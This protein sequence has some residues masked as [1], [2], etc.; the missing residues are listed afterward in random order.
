MKA[1]GVLALLSV[2]MWACGGG[3]TPSI[4][5]DVSVDPGAQGDVI[6]DAETSGGTD[7]PG[8]ANPEVAPEEGV[9]LPD[10]EEDFWDVANEGGPGEVVE[11]SGEDTLADEG[12]AL[13][14]PLIPCTND[15]DCEAAAVGPCHGLRCASGY[16]EMY[17]LEDGTPC[18]TGSVCELSGACVS[19]QCIGK[20]LDCDDGNVCTDDSCDPKEGCVHKPNSEP[21]DDQN[22]CTDTSTCEGGVCVGHD[23]KCQC[24]TD[25]D[26]A[27]KNDDDLCNGVLH[28]VSGHCE[29]DPN[30]VVKCDG[31]AKDAC[32]TLVCEPKTGQCVPTPA[33]NGTP[34]DDGSKCTTL[35]QCIDG[36]CVGGTP[37]SCDDQNPCTDDAC[38]LAA[39]CTHTPNS[40]PCD[41]QDFCT[42]GDVCKDGKCVGQTPRDCSDG[43]PC[44]DDRCEGTSC[45][46]DPNSAPCDD[47]DPCTSNDYCEQG[48]CVGHGEPDCDDKNP[49][50]QDSCEKG[51]GCVHKPLSAVPCDDGNACTV[52]SGCVD[53]VCKGGTPVACDDNNICTDDSCDPVKG[54]VFTPNSRPCDDQ[55]PCTTGDHCQASECVGGPAPS[56]DDLN[57]CTDDSCDPAKGC[58]HVFN[59][60]PCEDGSACTQNDQCVLGQCV[61]GKAVDCDDNNLCTTDSCDPAKGCV[62]TP[63]TLPCDDGNACTEGDRCSNGVCQGGSTKVCMDGNPCTTDNC[64]PK[65]GCVFTPKPDN[66]TCDDGNACTSN[67]KCSQGQCVG[68][69]TQ[70]NDGNPCTDDRCNSVQGCYYVNNTN[71]CDDNNRCTEGDVCSNGQCAGKPISCDDGNVCT[72]DL[73]DKAIGCYYQFNTKDCE[74]GN[75][76]TLGDKCQ[77][78][79]CVPGSGTPN[80]DDNNPC[81]TDS[82]DPKLGCQNVPNTLPCNDGDVCTEND[83]CSNGQ[84][85]GTPVSCDDH[86]VCTKDVCLAGTGCVHQYVTGPCDDGNKCTSNDQCT[87]GQCSGTPVLCDDHN[88]CTTDSCDPAKG[89]VFTYNTLPCDD[90]KVCTTQDQC[91]GGQCVGGPAPNCD[92]GNICTDD[93]C[94]E[95]DGCFHKNNTLPC[96]DNDACTGPDVCSGG[97]C[98]G[99]AISCDDHNDCTSDWCDHTYGCQHSNV[100]NGTPCKLGVKVG[101]CL[102][103]KCVAWDVKA[104]NPQGEQMTW[105]YEGGRPQAN[106]GLYA[107]GGNAFLPRIYVV[108]SDL[109]VSVAYTYPGTIT[110]GQ[111]Y[112]QFGSL[113]GGSGGIS[114]RYVGAGPVGWTNGPSFDTQQDVLSISQIPPQNNTYFVTGKAAGSWALVQSTIRRCTL[115]QDTECLVMGLVAS[116]NN[117]CKQKAVEL[118][119]SYVAGATRAFAV[120]MEQT[121]IGFGNLVIASWDG[122]SQPL[123]CGDKIQ[124]PGGVFYYD[125]SD[126]SSLMMPIQ[127]QGPG[128]LNDVHG[129]ALNDVW[130]VG[131]KGSVFWYNG[132]KWTQMSPA[133][134]LPSSGYGANHN[135]QSVWVD[136][137]TGVH[138][139]GTRY[140]GDFLVCQVPFYL[141][142]VRDQVS[143]AYKFN[144]YT[145]FTDYQVCGQGE[146]RLSDLYMDSV[147]SAL[148]VFGWLQKATANVQALVM[149]IQRPQTPVPLTY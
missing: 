45:V 118:R 43:N 129:A 66:T 149:R 108:N 52:D 140:S 79:V 22:P 42:V 98:S 81:T 132:M 86:N 142:A 21:C 138:V 62:H 29:V 141:H 128:A 116:K 56:C 70:C 105:L 31:P 57:P 107:S 144:N 73:C 48:L 95:P 54:C 74:D 50:T 114:A 136:P 14:L 2:F 64:D 37:L 27:D 69:G 134:D 143:G 101:M 87:N 25:K 112:A 26:C 33:Q 97:Q 133:K 135:A 90:G 91:Q 40:A 147:S 17:P 120:G 65:T 16:C 71:P 92:D 111:F 23:N 106:A 7:M 46:H 77:K 44:T 82:C 146:V 1:Q 104:S 75:L 127:A 38:D 61:G 84:C 78:G 34:C 53:G 100:P 148:Y 35:D 124:F 88:I 4:S 115:G 103:G 89:C 137:I 39:G 30:T 139:V 49:C 67:D 68:Q 15:E 131:E 60:A 122:N 123:K 8:E 113:A 125:A 93:G 76:C 102:V 20:P 117:I 6:G 12:G 99:P 119:G 51:T 11:V 19:G 47:K 72:E 110:N 109:S 85:K 3:S 130:A 80:C 121:M 36:Q 55:N 5:T 10:I 41:D 32:H 9:N 58:V 126:G 63:N 28:C 96:D 145:E 24:T 83:T 18:D 94:A 59:S 13:E